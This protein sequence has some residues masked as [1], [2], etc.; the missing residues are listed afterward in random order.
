MLVILYVL[1][2]VKLVILYVLVDVL[3]VI[4]YASVEVMSVIPH[5]F[6]HLFLITSWFYTLKTMV[7]LRSTEHTGMQYHV[8]Y[9]YNV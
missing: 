6:R 8:S 7:Q 1:L 2:K 4:L 3:L 5:I 9:P